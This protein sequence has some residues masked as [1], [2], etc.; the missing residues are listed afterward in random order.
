[1]AWFLLLI[2]IALICSSAVMHPEQ[3]LLHSGRA[4]L[5]AA[6]LWLNF[7]RRF[8]AASLLL[9]AVTVLSVLAYLFT[10]SHETVAPFSLM[11]VALAASYL[12]TP[13]SLGL[14]VAAVIIILAVAVRYWQVYGHS[15]VSPMYHVSLVVVGLFYWLLIWLKGQARDLAE[16]SATEAYELKNILDATVDGIVTIDESATVLSFNKAA[17]NLFGYSASEVIGKNVRM[18]M[19]EPYRAEHDGYVHRYLETGVGRIIG[20]GERIVKGQRADGTTFP[21]ELA[22][23]RAAHGTGY[24]FTGLVRDVSA[25]LASEAELKRKARTDALTGLHNRLGLDEFL[26]KDWPRIR[27]EGKAISVLMLDVDYFKKYNDT[28]GHG[29]GDQTLI[30][31]ASAIAAAAEK[32]ADFAARYGGEE[33]CVLLPG[34]NETGAL[35]VAENIR[36]ILRDMKISHT[37]STTGDVTVSIGLVTAGPGDAA[38]ASEMMKRADE[39]LYAAKQGGRDR[40]HVFSQ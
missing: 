13:R 14:G 28:Y 2:S 23:S 4:L 15:G 39:A 21:L 26:G 36:R 5:S 25:R 17:E 35:L 9:L 1:M 38:E 24:V 32:R 11:A 12:V 18:L 22:V 3:V 33:F 7:T 20:V 27:A 6:T 19:P 10:A 16:H 37:A 40:V 31:V 30:L 8:L 34:T 29:Q